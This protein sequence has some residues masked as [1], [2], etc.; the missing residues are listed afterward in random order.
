MQWNKLTISLDNQAVAAASEIL[1]QAGSLGN[2]IDDLDFQGDSRQPVKLI[3]YFNI[4]P[5]WDQNFT[6]IKQQLNSLRNCQLKVGALTWKVVQVDE[7]TWQHQWENYYNIQHISHFLTI[8]PAWKKYCSKFQGEIVLK[9]NPGQSFG[10]GMH[11][12]TIL[13]LQALEESLLTNQSV[14]DVG[15]GSGI[16]SLASSL[17]GAEWVDGYE[18]DVLALAAAK[19]N[20]QL[21]GLAKNV[22][23]MQSNLLQ[24]A[25]RP[26][27]LIIANLLPN[28]ILQLLPTVAH[29]LKSKGKL[30]L[31]GIILEKQTIVETAL[32]QNNFT[33]LQKSQLKNWLGIVA[34]KND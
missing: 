14:I 29:Y 4:T 7:E 11:P 16:L 17:L 13:A 34:Q 25:R 2:Q 18:L 26:A 19:K 30:I 8:V 9:L 1:L 6:E 10:T 23:F 27:D 32:L 5:E 15:A 24:N 21:N 3:G 33:V 22:S 28:L 12:T 20:L 31:S